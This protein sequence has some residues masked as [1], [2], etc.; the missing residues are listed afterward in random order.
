[1]TQISFKRIMQSTIIATC[2]LS[3]FSTAHAE[4]LYVVN[5]QSRTLSRIDTSTDVVNNSFASLGNVP[6][7]IVVDTDF[8][9]SVNSGD[10][11]VQKISRETGAILA[12]ILIAIGSNPWDAVLHQNNL[13]VTGLFTGKVY[14]LD[15]IS[16]TVT[17]NVSV[18]TA[19]EALLVLGNKLYVSNAGNYTQNYAGSS[20]SVIDLDSFTLLSTIPVS[21]N[22]QYL[23]SHNGMLHVSCTGNWTDIGGAVCIID[24]ATDTLVHTIEIGSTPG[25]IWIANQSLAYVADSN[26]MYLFSYHPE[27]YQLLYGS[28]NPLPD[29]GSEIV[30]NSSLIA[31]LSPNWSGNGTVKI[32]HPDLTPWKQYTVAM[33]PTDLKMYSAPTNAYDPVLQIPKLSVYPNPARQGTTLK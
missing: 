26:G 24:P 19:P 17:G 20:V 16:G 6:N 4:I 14:R 27:T 28:S 3:L 5:S 11:A 33:M 9:W 18:G 31:I 23:A 7:K 12:N 1:M 32:F 10:N 15:T 21:A 8:I 13:Y 30:G 25:R 2:L 22:P 29:G